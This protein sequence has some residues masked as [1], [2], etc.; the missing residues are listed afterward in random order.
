MIKLK[1]RQEQVLDLVC[2]GYET[3]QIAERLGLAEA[4]IKNN[5]GQLYNIF[6]VDNRVRLTVAAIKIGMFDIY[7]TE[8]KR[9]P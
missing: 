3:K 2:Q 5:L 7:A 8:P 6:V 1:E 9:K 4:T